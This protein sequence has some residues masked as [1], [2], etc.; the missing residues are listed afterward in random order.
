MADSTPE[1][2]PRKQTGSNVAAGAKRKKNGEPKFYAVKVGFRPG[3]Y[4]RWEECLTQVTG[5]KGAIFQSFPS[6]AEA[7][8]FLAGIKLISANGSTAQITKFYGIQKGR[9]PGV[10]TDWTE[11]Q[12]QIKGVRGPKFRKFAT[13]EEAE[14]Y[15]RQGQEPAD[16]TLLPGAPGLRPERPKDELGNEYPAGTGPLPSGAE[17]GFDPNVLLDPSTGRIVYKNSQQKGATKLAPKSSGSGG[18]LN[19]YTDGSAIKNGMAG[20]RAGVGVY[21]GPGDES[22]NVS[23]PLKGERQTN[24]RAELTAIS[25]ALSIAPR[26][27]DV[28]IYTDSKY[29]INCVTVW[30]VNW[31]RNNWMTSDNRPVENKDLIQPIIAKIEERTGLNVKTLFQWVKGH[32]RDPGNEAAD[33][34]AVRGAGLEP[35]DGPQAVGEDFEE[36]EDYDE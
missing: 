18:M 36:V 26:H 29:S 31:K 19:I 34:L 28:T 25:R 5:Y 10:Y 7:N 21:F 2:V 1:A 35:N 11:A 23:E 13:R 32:S 8:A 22:R 27:R 12:D 9:T 14:E 33:R 4:N 30:C 24:Q 15:V 20:A 16:N 6:L 17:D 3:V